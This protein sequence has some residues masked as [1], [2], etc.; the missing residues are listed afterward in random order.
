LQYTFRSIHSCF[1]MEFSFWIA[2][3]E[4]GCARQQMHCCAFTALG[5]L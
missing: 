5:L 2:D 4:M 1:G 3:K